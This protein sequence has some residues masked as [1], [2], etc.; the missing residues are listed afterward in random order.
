MPE[1]PRPLDRLNFALD[2]AAIG[3]WDW[4]IT[5]GGLWWSD[6]LVAIPGLSPDDFDGTFERFLSFIHADDR[7]GFLETMERAIRQDNEFVIDFRVIGAD[8]A[9]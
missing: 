3:L 7:R 4:D 1:A 8:G 9:D 6:N 5:T 2:A